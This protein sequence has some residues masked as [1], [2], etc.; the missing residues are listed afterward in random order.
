[1]NLTTYKKKD[2]QKYNDSQLISIRKSILQECFT[3]YN[4]KDKYE[5]TCKALTV[6][7]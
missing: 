7:I 1:M 2:N 4:F 3:D 6:C 5:Y